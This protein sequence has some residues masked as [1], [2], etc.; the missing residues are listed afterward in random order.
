M[1]GVSGLVGLN[2]DGGPPEEVALVPVG[3]RVE[4]G[5]CL[6]VVFADFVVGDAAGPDGLELVSNLALGVD[7]SV[8]ER[9]SPDVDF[10]AAGDGAVPVAMTFV[11]A[12]VEI[13]LLIALAGV[14]G[15]VFDD[16]ANFE[17]RPLDDRGILLPVWLI[18]EDAEASRREAVA[19]IVCAV[20][21]A[22]DDGVFDSSREPGA[23]DRRVLSAVGRVDGWVGV[24]VDTGVGILL[25]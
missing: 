12:E 22:V 23:D 3:M 15:L 6:G 7:E 1:A 16:D 9:F 17:C 19:P 13:A 24:P 18:D 10:I 4:A 2:D 5:L 11:V 20:G 8:L 25:R 14:V 21:S